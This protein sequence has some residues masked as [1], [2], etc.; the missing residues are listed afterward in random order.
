MSNKQFNFLQHVFTL[1]KQQGRA[2]MVILDNVLF[3][4]RA[5]ECLRGSA[6]K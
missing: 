2:A 6:F 5:G 3:E 4:G 1:S